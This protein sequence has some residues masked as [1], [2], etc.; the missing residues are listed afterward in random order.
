[1]LLRLRLS[2]RRQP[3]EG[4]P[5]EARCRFVCWSPRLGCNDFRRD[6][7]EARQTT[8]AKIQMMLPMT[9]QGSRASRDD[10]GNLG[11]TLLIRVIKSQWGGD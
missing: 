7:S 10:K 1:L 11:V 2:E 8:S 5:Q 4:R 3:T 6:R 9:G